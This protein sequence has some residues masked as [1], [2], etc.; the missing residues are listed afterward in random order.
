MSSA[1]DEEVAARLAGFVFP[2]V[3]PV[4][5]AEF[6]SELLDDGADPQS[7]KRVASTL[8]SSINDVNETDTK[9]KEY[10]PR[11]H[12]ERVPKEESHWYR[13]Y[14]AEE[15][16]RSIEVGEKGEGEP[17]DN[18]L[19][20]DF[21]ALQQ[22]TT[23]AKKQMT[24]LK[25]VCKPYECLVGN[26]NINIFHHIIRGMSDILCNGVLSKFTVFGGQAKKTNR[27]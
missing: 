1:E 8:S 26:I 18:K 7:K 4:I 13:R 19:A 24:S 14:L 10:K 27:K 22:D 6:M 16:Q 20:K 12:M 9:T 23:D 11:A 5:G 17:Q 15:R 21:A 2:D 3:N 25:L